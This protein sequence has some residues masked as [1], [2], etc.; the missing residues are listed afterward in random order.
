MNTFIH[1]LL[2]TFIHTYYINIDDLYAINDNLGFDRNHKDIYPSEL[3]IKEESILLSGK[4]FLTPFSITV[5]KKKK[6]Y[7]TRKISS[8]FL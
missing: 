8:F 1:I 2:N 3:Q 6:N 4:S 7:S 5:E